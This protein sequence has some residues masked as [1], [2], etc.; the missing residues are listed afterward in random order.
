MGILDSIG[1]T[2][3][4]AQLGAEIK[5]VERE[6][7]QRIQA[8]GVELYD[9]IRNSEDA[10]I[11]NVTA[12]ASLKTPLDACTADVRKMEQEVAGQKNDRELIEVRPDKDKGSLGRRVG[13]QAAITKIA[14]RIAY[15]EREMRLRKQKFG[16]QVW[17]IVSE[18]QWLKSTSGGGLSGQE[19]AIQACVDKA[20][21]DIQQI[22]K[23]IQGKLDQIA[24]LRKSPVTVSS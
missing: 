18:P 8:L 13:D 4:K 5:L 2:A 9:L 3:R 10:A 14:T 22:D 24:A 20:K 11:P 15:L 6:R 17:E 16:M 21:D 19:L 7:N 12:V 1:S 23:R